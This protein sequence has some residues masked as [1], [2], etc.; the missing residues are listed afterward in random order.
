MLN[1]S[2]AYECFKMKQSL[3]LFES[4]KM[5]ASRKQYGYCPDKFLEWE[6]MAEPDQLLTLND[7]FLQIWRNF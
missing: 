1:N 4:G 7:S 6:K 5:E 2:G 3:L